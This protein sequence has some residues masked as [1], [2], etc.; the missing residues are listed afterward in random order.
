[1]L[2][3]G[4]L[5]RGGS[6]ALVFAASQ[7]RRDHGGATPVARA[8]APS[9][10]DLRWVVGEILLEP[11]V[12][13]SASHVSAADLLDALDQET[14]AW[15]D[16]LAGCG[17]PRLR[18]APLR[19]NGAAREDGRNVVVISASS[20]CPA[21]NQGLPACYEPDKQA[22]THVRPRE[23]LPHVGE[24]REA[25]IEVNAVNFHW[26]LDG[27]VPGTRSLRAVLAHELGHVLGLD[28]SC[29]PRPVGLSEP[30]AGILPACAAKGASRS[31]MY[32]DPT[33]AGHALV[34]QPGEDAVRG[35]CGRGAPRAGAGCGPA[36]RR[37]L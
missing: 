18:T 12:P 17:A 4:W 16:A 10:I 28:H 21:D 32:P 20:W 6:I 37:E 35:L 9:G 1:M 3:R 29:A 5:R 19:G 14:Q 11:V 2:P 26:S 24:I 25:D 34:L 15:N 31:I 13:P 7:C 36:L 23:D 22:I 33:E 30:D 8:R 27:D